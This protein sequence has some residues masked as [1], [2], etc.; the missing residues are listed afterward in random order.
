MKLPWL[1]QVILV[2]RD[3]LAMASVASESRI[4]SSQNGLS[5]N[6]TVNVKRGLFP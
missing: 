2:D 5:P 3:G 4:V 1:L 6:D